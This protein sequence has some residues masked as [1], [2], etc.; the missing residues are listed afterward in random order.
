MN[1]R[2]KFAKSLG[3]KVVE[4]YFSNMYNAH[5]DRVINANPGSIKMD[6]IN[7]LKKEIVD[8]KLTDAKV[9]LAKIDI[10][11]AVCNDNQSQLL[12]TVEKNAKVI[13]GELFPANIVYRVKG[14]ITPAQQERWIKVLETVKTRCTYP[15]TERQ[16][17]GFVDY[18]KM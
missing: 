17:Q 2:D 16:I 7:R 6:S 5:M 3:K 9:L 13:P 8:L 11:K 15:G 4:Q 14:N 12:A 1:N 10:A 18:L